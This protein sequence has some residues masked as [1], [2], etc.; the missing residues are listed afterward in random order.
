MRRADLRNLAC[1]FA[2]LMGSF[3]LA[4]GA[5]A[6]PLAPSLFELREQGGGVVAVRFRTP[7]FQRP[8]AA[9]VPELPATCRARGAPELAGDAAGVSFRWLADCPLAGLR[10]A[11]VRVGGL[12]E[13]GTDALLR[14]ELADGEIL[15]AVLRP[16]AER[17]AIPLRPSRVG[18]ASSYLRMGFEHLLGGVDHL[19]FVLGLVLL[20]RDRRR[21]LVGITGFTLGH[22][23]TLS[24]AVLGLVRVPTG[25]VEIGIAA[26]LFWLATRLA[27][28]G[29]RD[30][31]LAHPW[32]IAAVFG[33]LHGFG[34]AGALAQA[35]LPAGEIPLALFAFNLGI[36]AG[37][38][39]AIAGFLVLAAVFAP[40]R[41]R[42]PDWLSR[43][44]VYAI[45]ATAAALIFERA[46]A[47]L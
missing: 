8:G 17:F 28:G 36:E 13:S 5:S 34:F 10:G 22:S 23:L 46:A 20:L 24:L 26:S 29:Q 42:A 30:V 25:A 43:V 38:L 32:R 33:L 12:R 7:R 39:A 41:E 11:S 2:A 15:R 18:V 16:G 19:L 40:W 31:L 1:G 37:Q 14:V 6:H 27:R 35:G 9:V 44:P 47:L 45:G 21:L 3:G 4:P